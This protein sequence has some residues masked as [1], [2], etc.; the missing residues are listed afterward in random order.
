[1]GLASKPSALES[2]IRIHYRGS[3][4]LTN[5]IGFRP[6]GLGVGSASGPKGVGGRVRV[7]TQRG[8]GMGS[9]PDLRK[10]GLC[11]DPRGGVLGKTQA[12]WSLGM[13]QDLKELGVEPC[14]DL[15]ELRGGWVCVR[16]RTQK[17]SGVWIHGRTQRGWGLGVGGWVHPC[18]DPRGVRGLC[19]C[20]DPR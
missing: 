9:S 1:L 6:R 13:W 10:L 14:L 18:P 12:A 4:R 15:K 16:V 17:G 11:S 20:P 2:F 7:R 8:R 3:R 19:S 5:R